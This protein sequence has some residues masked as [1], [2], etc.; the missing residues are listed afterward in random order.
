MVLL[1]VTKLEEGLWITH[2][3]DFWRHG[4]RQTGIQ[5]YERCALF[6]KMLCIKTSREQSSILTNLLD[7]GD[8]NITSRSGVISSGIQSNQIPT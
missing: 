3:I 2:I 7:L 6:V 4:K 8:V 5:K 1:S